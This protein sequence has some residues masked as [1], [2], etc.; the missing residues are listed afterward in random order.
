MRKA[1]KLDLAVDSSCMIPTFG[2]EY[3]PRVVKAQAFFEFRSSV[4]VTWSGEHS[5]NIGGSEI[6]ARAYFP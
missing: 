4:S 2:S 6:F 3:D 5:S 1:Q